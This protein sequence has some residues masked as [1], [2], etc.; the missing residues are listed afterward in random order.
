MKAFR[1]E[2]V[3]FGI[4]LRVFSKLAFSSELGFERKC[5]AVVAAIHDSN[6]L[7]ND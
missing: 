6:L 5:R 4:L 3:M 1:E 7:A 2:K